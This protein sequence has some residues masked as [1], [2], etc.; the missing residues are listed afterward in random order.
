MEPVGG[1][2]CITPTLAQACDVCVTL[3]GAGLESGTQPRIEADI[4]ADGRPGCP[5]RPYRCSRSK[6]ADHMLR[7]Q[8]PL[9]ARY[10]AATADE[11][12]DMI[13]HA[14]EELGSRV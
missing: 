12:P 11:L 10:P 6:G 5:R 14:K 4:P 1:R 7:L 13:G 3:I 8:A 9:S 2:Y